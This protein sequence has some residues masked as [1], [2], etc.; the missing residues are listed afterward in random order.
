MSFLLFL[1]I[2]IGVSS[3]GLVRIQSH[4]MTNLTSLFRRVP[5]QKFNMTQ[6]KTLVDDAIKSKPVAVFAKR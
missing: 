2:I 4:R 6:V 5:F 3:K 1:L